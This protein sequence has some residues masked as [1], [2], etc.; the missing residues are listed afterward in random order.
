MTFKYTRLGV[1][2]KP[3][4]ERRAFL[5]ANERPIGEQKKRCIRHGTLPDGKVKGSVCLEKTASSVTRQIR[6]IDLFAGC[7]GLSEGF[8]QAGYTPVAHVEM[9]EAAC[10][11]LK[12]RMAYHWLKKNG[13]LADYCAYLRGEISR[14]EFYEKISSQILDSVINEEVGEKTLESLFE[15]IDAAKGDE[16]IDLIVGGPPCQAYSLVGRAS[17]KKH[18]KGDPRNYLFKFYIKFLEKYQPKCFV[19]ENV[20]GLLSAADENGKKYLDMMK[21][22][23]KAAGYAVAHRVINTKELG[24]PQ[25]RKRVIIIGQRDVEKVD[26]PDISG[27]EFAYTV[28]DMF[29]GLPHMKA[30]EHREPFNI[31]VKGKGREALEATSVLDEDVPVTQHQVRPN[32]KT[33]LEIYRR[34]VKLWND[35]GKRLSYE[36]LPKSLRT[37]TNLASF[38]DRY[39]VVDGAAHASHT[40]IAHIAKDGHYYIHPD[41]DQNRSLSVREAARLQTF[42]D[43]YYFESGSHQAGRA[44]PYR[45]IGNAVPVMLAKKIADAMKGFWK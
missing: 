24:V 10:F 12:T 13:K 38:R 14:D 32:N 36:Q 30:G 3:K 39:K 19:F 6:F 44:A 16:A 20:I 43:N 27:T 8:I 23:F 15:K 5:F 4:T 25:A 37:R 17:D 7:G 31:N 28:R 11:T 29:A 18:M 45:Q 40:V 42:P 34:V 26:Y 1:H 33:D 41:I 22:G 9:N 2:L 21:E 35:E